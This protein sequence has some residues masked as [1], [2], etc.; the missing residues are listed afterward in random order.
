PLT[1]LWVTGTGRT[2]DFEVEAQAARRQILRESLSS[3]L[4]VTATAL[5]RI[6]RRNLR[7]RDYTLTAIRHTLVELLVHF[8]TYRIY[9]G[10]G[11]ISEPDQRQMDWA[12]AGARRT[13]R[14]ADRPLLEQI[15]QWLSGTGLRSA[16]AGTPRQ[17]W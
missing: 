10:P 5:H 17:E 3:E 11:G 15:G 16:P 13:V 1:L 6:A 2:G 9:A 4:F 7:T 8:H 12:M 14:T